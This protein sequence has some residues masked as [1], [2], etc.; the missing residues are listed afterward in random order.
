MCAEK[1]R[2]FFKS[3]LPSPKDLIT[4]EILESNGR[5]SILKKADGT[6]CLRNEITNDE[7][8]HFLTIEDAKANWIEIVTDEEAHS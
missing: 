6:F 5:I 4:E 2:K 8:G 1:I 7:N 3:S